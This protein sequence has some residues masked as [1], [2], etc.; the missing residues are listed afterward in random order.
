MC[1][2]FAMGLQARLGEM[3]RV[4]S[5]D[6]EVMKLIITAA[7]KLPVPTVPWWLQE[8]DEEDEEDPKPGSDS[9]ESGSDEED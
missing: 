4:L 6:D 5:L 8:S 3:S 1:E 7:N 9:S 2:A